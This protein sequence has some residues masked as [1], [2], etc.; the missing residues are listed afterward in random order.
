MHPVSEVFSALWPQ[1]RCRNLLDDSLS[2][3]LEAQGMGPAMVDRMVGLAGYAR[4]HGADAVLFTCSAF[5]VAIEAAQKVHDI[6]ILKPNEAMFDEALDLCQALPR[7]GRIGLLTTFA[8]ASASMQQELQETIA[9]RQLSVTVEAVC[10]EGALARLQ[11]GD[12][13][14]HDQMVLNAAQ[15]MP[16]CDVYVVGQF[17]MARTQPLLA[18]A[19]GQPVLT[20][21]T[22]AV[23]RLKT[24]LGV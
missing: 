11:A 1:A 24:A 9:Q 18:A 8:P 12:G 4:T 19:L 14:A 7:S 5:G 22:S 2:P 21:P 10:A 16:L 20:S 3:D 15:R 13:T 23:H 17:S 6:P